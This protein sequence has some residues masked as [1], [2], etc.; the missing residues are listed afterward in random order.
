[1]GIDETMVT[2]TDETSG[3]TSALRANETKASAATPTCSATDPARAPQFEEGHSE[4][5]RRN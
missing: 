3:V 4:E 2:G 1:M 5:D